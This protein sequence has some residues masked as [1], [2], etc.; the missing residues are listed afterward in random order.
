MV[1]EFTET[2]HSVGEEEGQ[3]EVCLSL[4]TPTATP[5]AVY[6]EAIQDTPTSAQGL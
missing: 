6:L 2:E 1:V 4:D 3:V 5:L